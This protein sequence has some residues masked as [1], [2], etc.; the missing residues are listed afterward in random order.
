MYKIL[1]VI[2]FASVW[3]STLQ[4]KVNNKWINLIVGILI[5][6]G[7]IWCAITDKPSQS[8]KKPEVS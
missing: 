3:V 1:Y 8:I 4:H 5:V 7:T 6:A 2:I